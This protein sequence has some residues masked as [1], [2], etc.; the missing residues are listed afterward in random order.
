MQEE[1]VK[2]GMGGRRRS[3]GLDRINISYAHVGLGE[4]G[5]DEV[6]AKATWNEARGCLGIFRLP[7]GVVG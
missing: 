2:I 3:Q 1:G 6:L 7:E 4:I 5:E